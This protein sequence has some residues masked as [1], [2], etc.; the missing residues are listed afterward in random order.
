MASGL[1]CPF[2][3]LDFTPGLGKDVRAPLI[4]WS[5]EVFK[6]IG[7]SLGL[8]Y[9]EYTSFYDSGYMGMARILVGLDLSK[10]LV[11]SII[12]RKG[13]AIFYQALDYEGIP[14]KCGQC[15]E[16]GNLAKDFSL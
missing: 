8:F 11:D 14:F 1:R 10:G 13:P 2:T 15:H 6:E 12:I 4:L 7:N 5:E 3:H 16:Y 9:E